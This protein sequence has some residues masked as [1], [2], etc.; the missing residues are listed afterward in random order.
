MCI[1][2]RTLRCLSGRECFATTTS[3]PYR[4]L[5]NPRNRHERPFLT[6]LKALSAQRRTTSTPSTC[7]SQEHAQHQYNSAVPA[8]RYMPAGRSVPGL[9]EQLPRRVPAGSGLLCKWAATSVDRAFKTHRPADPA[10]H[11]PRNVS[12]DPA[13]HPR[14]CLPCK[15]PLRPRY[16]QVNKLAIRPA[17]ADFVNH[18]SRRQ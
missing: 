2:W 5:I 18:G 8:K 7:Y 6:S 15:R 4:G 1:P 9:P 13:K 17:A 16:Q 14:R 11:R 3:T 10:Y 12:H